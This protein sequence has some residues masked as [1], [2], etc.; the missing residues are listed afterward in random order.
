[1]SETQKVDANY[2]SPKKISQINATTLGIS[3][4]DGLESS[5]DVKML[6]EKCPC[7]NCIDEWTGEKRIQPGQIKDSIRP[8]NIK[9][10]GRYAVQFYWNDGHDTGLYT[11]DY[12]RELG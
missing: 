10:V 3:W 5:Y 12:L 8:V 7:A 4:S 9:S 11:H 6:R 2:P 1:M